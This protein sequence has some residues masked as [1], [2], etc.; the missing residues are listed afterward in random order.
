[1]S[2]V[3]N[4]FLYYIPFSL[5]YSAMNPPKECYCKLLTYGAPILYFI[6]SLSSFHYTVIGIYLHMYPAI[7]L[8]YYRPFMPFFL[9]LQGGISFLNDVY[10]YDKHIHWSSFLD[11][12]FA[13]YIFIQFIYQAFYIRWSQLEIC[14]IF[15]GVT[16]KA[17]SS[18]YGSANDGYRYMVYH[19]LWHTI[20]PVLGIYKAITAV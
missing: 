2:A 10:Y 18:Y 13:S 11:R 9:M 12:S 6:Y 1:M 14:V 3:I 7:L 16:A 15:M 4:Q 17:G 20:L 8:E 19:I 5:L